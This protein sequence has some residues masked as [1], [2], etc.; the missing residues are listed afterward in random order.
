MAIY[1]TPTNSSGGGLWVPPYSLADGVYSV[2]G[3][4]VYG[5][6]SGPLG[7]GI[8]LTMP[9]AAKSATLGII[10]R[11]SAAPPAG[12]AEAMYALIAS[13]M[14]VGIWSKLDILYLMAAHHEQAARLNWISASYNLAAYNSP[15]FTA[16]RGFKGD[17]STAW[18]DVV[19]YN[20]SSTAG[21]FALN[22]ASAG[23]WVLTP[24]AGTG[25]DLSGVVWMSRRNTGVDW[26]YRV[27]DGTSSFGQ[28][29]DT[30]GFYAGDRPSSSTKRLFKNGAQIATHNVAS[31]VLYNRLNILGQSGGNNSSAELAV[32]FAGA[33]LTET[34]HAAL[35][36]AL[37]TYLLTIGAISA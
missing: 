19:G 17:G 6:P 26:H 1:S 22:D 18:L 4:S 29:G 12:R 11:M 5:G 7:P 35:Y 36:A 30:P 10:G 16:N 23:L 37:S 24:S 3:R 8:S 31:S 21:R 28:P 34:Q 27:N 15:I 13:L 33:S 14:T 20:P 25:M 32:V 2:Q 9:N